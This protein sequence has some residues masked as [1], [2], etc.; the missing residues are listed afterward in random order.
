MIAIIQLCFY[1]QEKDF[2][3]LKKKLQKIGF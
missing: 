1:K 3:V 2:F